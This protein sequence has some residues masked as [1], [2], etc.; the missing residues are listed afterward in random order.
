MISVLKAELIRYKLINYRNWRE[1]VKTIFLN[2]TIM[3]LIYLMFSKELSGEYI[4]IYSMVWFILSLQL[5]VTKELS[6]DFKNKT[7]KYY[8]KKFIY[9]FFIRYIFHLIKSILVIYLILNFMW[10]ID[11]IVYKFNFIDC[12]ILFIGGVSLYWIN[13]IIAL[14]SILLK[15]HQTIINLLRVMILY[16]LVSMN[17][18]F[19]PFSVSSNVLAS[20]LLDIQISVNIYFLIIN[21]VIYLTL[22]LI[23]I[24]FINSKL[25]NKV[26]I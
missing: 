11:I 15:K 23:V 20:K 19:L 22:G 24:K 7:I 2:L 17:S 5:N 12:F 10:V 26:L 21:S 3:I 9:V 25:I 16:F 4:A 8:K 18:I 14:S 1:L 13:Y 6:E